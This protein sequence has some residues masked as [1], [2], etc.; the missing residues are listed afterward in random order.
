MNIDLSQPQYI[1]WLIVGVMGL[2]LALYL[3]SQS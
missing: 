1:I 2:I 3:Y